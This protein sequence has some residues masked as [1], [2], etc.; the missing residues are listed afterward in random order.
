[1]RFT[2]RLINLIVMRKRA[3]KLDRK[4]LC[5]EC[6]YAVYPCQTIRLLNINLGPGDL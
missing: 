2:D 3:R 4:A 6:D 5:T 1:M